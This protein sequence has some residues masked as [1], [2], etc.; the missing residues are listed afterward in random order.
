MTAAA[1]LFPA[2]FGLA[3]VLAER[4][5]AVASGLGLIFFARAPA[6]VVFAVVFVLDVFLADRA[7]AHPAVLAAPRPLC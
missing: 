6:A 2:V 7:F 5:V 4:D 1:L 3:S